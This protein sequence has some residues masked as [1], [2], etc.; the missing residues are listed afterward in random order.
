MKFIIF[1]PLILLL[2]GCGDRVKDDPRFHPIRDQFVKDAKKFGVN[3]DVSRVRIAFEDLD[4]PT[5]ILGFKIKKKSDFASADG[6]C[7]YLERDVHND[8]KKTFYKVATPNSYHLMIIQI[9]P[10]LSSRPAEFLES[11]VY[12]ELGHCVLNLPHNNNEA[13]M[14][15]NGIYSLNGFR[16]FDLKELFERQLRNI[17]SIQKMTKDNKNDPN[18]KL[19]YQT[20]YI[21]FDQ[22][23]FYELYYNDNQKLFFVN[24]DPSL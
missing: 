2:A 19:V 18:F 21:V 1:I 14:S 24:E 20:D 23:I 7:L 17:D 11:L 8:L 16:Y 3:V 13:I 22:R 5:K 9:N 15:T 4:K 12:H 6:T 10:T